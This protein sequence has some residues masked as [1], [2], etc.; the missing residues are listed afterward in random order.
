MPKKTK[1]AANYRETTSQDEFCRAC[2]F[3]LPSFRMDEVNSAPQYKTGSCSLVEGDIEPDNFTSDLFEPVGVP[4]LESLTENGVH[5]QLIGFEIDEATKF[6]TLPASNI[7]KSNLPK[8][9][10]LIAGESTNK[11]TWHMPFKDEKGNVNVGLLRAARQL[12][13]TGAF[14]GQKPGFTISES[15]KSRVNRLW[16]EWQ[17]VKERAASLQSGD[18]ELAEGINSLEYLDSDDASQGGTAHQ[19]ELTD[20]YEAC[21]NPELC[22]WTSGPVSESWESFDDETRE[23][24]VQIIRS[25]WSQNGNGYPGRYLKSLAEHLMRRPKMYMNHKLEGAHR[26]KI[27]RSPLEW[28]S[29]VKR[30]F[31]SIDKETGVACLKA[32]VQFSHYDVGEQTY[33]QAKM[34]PASVR[35]SIHARNL[36]NR[37][38][39][40][41]GR[42]GEVMEGVNFLYSTDYVSYDS[43]GGFVEVAN[44]LQVDGGETGYGIYHRYESPA[45]GDNKSANNNKSQMKRGEESMYEFKTAEE[46]LQNT[47]VKQAAL[48]S[49]EVLEAAFKQFRD[50]LKIGEEK[51]EHPVTKKEVTVTAVSEALVAAD[52][53]NKALKLKVEKFEAESGLR[54]RKVELDK[55][56]KEHK[57]TAKQVGEQTVNICLALDDDERPD[58]Y[59]SLSDD[60]KKKIQSWKQKMESIILERKEARDEIAREIHGKGN[61]TGSTK[62]ETAEWI[63]D[64]LKGKN[65]DGEK[66]ESEEELDERLLSR[67]G[68]EKKK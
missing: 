44:Q 31:E 57:L 8:S 45:K 22:D 13:T 36:V 52:K 53:E 64:A 61:G 51:I 38:G 21:E 62:S 25:G 49:R 35:L 11:S 66:A 54:N 67:L 17:R 5:Y 60:E 56:M 27:S 39:S 34:D 16:N 48:K 23:A 32:R 40:L 42:K 4:K 30:T 24:T 43:A 1:Q 29:T 12:V 19:A 47:D 3:F 9:A 2:R 41:M 33:L 10:F 65:G 26:E 37:Q 58:D 6:S 46:A 28:V 7:K 55:L 14:R 18:V 63:K 15:V 50:D 20:S 59:E 68:V